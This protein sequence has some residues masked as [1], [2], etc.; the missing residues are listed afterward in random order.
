MCGSV[1]VTVGV[2]QELETFLRLT[3]AVIKSNNNNNKNS[4]WRIE[5]TVWTGNSVLLCGTGNGFLV[6]TEGLLRRVSPSTRPLFSG[7]SIMGFVH[8]ASFCG[9]SENLRSRVQP[10]LAVSKGGVWAYR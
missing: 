6:F 10:R 9:W 3:R 4:V 7:L 2:I 5:S 8:R 1:Y